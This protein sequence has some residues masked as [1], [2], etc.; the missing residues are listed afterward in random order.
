MK[1]ENNGIR[2]LHM[3]VQYAMLE[4]IVKQIFKETMIEVLAEVR[5]HE[6][7]ERPLLTIAQIAKKFQVTKT[8]VHNWKTRGLIVGHKLGKNRY[9]TEDEVKDALLRY[10][11]DSRLKDQY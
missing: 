1:K 8:T 10:G 11:W 6:N 3:E 5:K 9:Y 4:H 7:R 2:D